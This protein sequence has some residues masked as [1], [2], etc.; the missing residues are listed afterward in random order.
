V[1]GVK[2]FT[3]R[4][5]E[6][7]NTNVNLGTGKHRFDFVAQNSTGNE[8]YVK[9]VFATVGDCGIP[10]TGGI[11]ICLP[12]NT[13]VSPVKIAA[14][15]RVSGTIY[16]FE[17]WVNG[18][19][20]VSVENSGTMKTTIS[21]PKGNLRFDFIARNTAGERIVKTKF[22]QVGGGSSCSVNSDG[23]VM[24]CSPVAGSTVSSPVHVS[25][26]CNM[27]FDI[28]VYIDSI[29]RFSDDGGVVSKDFTV[30]SGPHRLTVT[31]SHPPGVRETL[32]ISFTV[33]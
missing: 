24:I 20:K 32:T 25:A 11:N 16:R 31:G 9:T 21:L 18:V 7:L 29:L 28:H 15:A 2:V 10:A 22:V 8:R 33:R 17:L 30:A 4:E 13:A 12:G 1:D 26:T 6:N 23:F 27:C 14:Y 3:V 5:S 19:K